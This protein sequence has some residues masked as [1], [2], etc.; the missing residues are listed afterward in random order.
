ML[1]QFTK[2]FSDL[3]INIE[4][5]TNKSRGNYAYS[6][7]DIAEA[8]SEETAQKISSIKGVLKVRVIK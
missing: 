5:M 3:G 4:N 1:T 8:V 2:A 7:L 6:V